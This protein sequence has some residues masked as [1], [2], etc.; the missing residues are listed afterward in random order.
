[1]NSVVELL[2]SR[3]T[4]ANVEGHNLVSVAGY[5]PHLPRCIE[6]IKHALF[7]GNPVIIRLHAAADY[8]IDGEE[9]YQIDQEGQA[10]LIV[11]YDEEM[12]ALAVID[13]FARDRMKG[14][15]AQWISITEFEVTMVNSS[16][17]QSNGGGR[18]GGKW[19]HL[20]ET[21]RMLSVAVGFPTFRGS[22]MDHDS[23]TMDETKVA[24]RLLHSGGEHIDVARIAG[25]ILVGDDA[26]ATFQLPSDLTGAFTLETRVDTT[27]N[28]KRPYA[29]SDHIWNKWSQTFVIGSGERLPT[30]VAV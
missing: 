5:D 19:A 22:I 30:A 2:P 6:A 3:R 7:A 23:L 21:T 15:G 1:M 8:P 18:G 13:P 26:T 12:E 10:V 4:V 28:G 20:D 27:L 17:G 29:Y 11:G 25:S 16:R 24:I 9:K 14:P